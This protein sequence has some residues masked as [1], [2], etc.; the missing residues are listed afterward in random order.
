MTMPANWDQFAQKVMAKYTEQAR[1]KYCNEC[2]RPVIRI[3]VQTTSDEI[4][5]M[6]QERFGLCWECAGGST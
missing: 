5:R 2:G 1:N 6:R 4:A 3:R